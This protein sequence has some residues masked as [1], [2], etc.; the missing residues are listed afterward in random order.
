MEGQA[1]EKPFIQ[2]PNRSE[3]NL[4]VRT[5]PR[6]EA[7]AVCAPQS[8]KEKLKKEPKKATKKRKKGA[9]T[10]HHSPFHHAAAGGSCTPLCCANRTACQDYRPK[11]RMER[12]CAWCRRSST[13]AAGGGV[14]SC[15]TGPQPDKRSSLRRNRARPA[16]TGETHVLQVAGKF[17]NKGVMCSTMLRDA[18]LRNV[19][20]S[21]LARRENHKQLRFTTQ[22]P[23][24]G[25]RFA[26]H[27]DG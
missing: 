12:T 25:P 13:T 27:C 11:E 21:Y 6:S 17:G 22:R 7:I 26:R 8:K 2:G 9:S 3:E 19:L 10:Q 23:K 18:V 4:L 5:M 1:D 16:Q 20:A 24:S 15:G 14:S